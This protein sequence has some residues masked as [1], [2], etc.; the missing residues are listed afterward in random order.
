MQG[1]LEGKEGN[2]ADVVVVEPAQP[3][4]RAKRALKRSEPASGEEKLPGQGL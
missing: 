3:A 4:P 2:M 1:R